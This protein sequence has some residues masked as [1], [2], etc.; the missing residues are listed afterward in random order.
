MSKHIVIIFLTLLSLEAVSQTTHNNE[1]VA[2]GSS[3]TKVKP[4][5]VIFTITVSKIDTS[6]KNS[7]KLLNL[8][9]N[10]LVKNLNEIGIDNKSIKISDYSISKSQN[11][12]NKEEYI[13]T[14][15]LKV[16][17]VIDTKLVNSLYNK[18]QEADLKDM[19]VS[20][21]TKLSDSLEKAIRLKL[22]Q[23]SIE[24]AKINANN[25]ANTLNI[26]L[27]GVKQVHK[28]SVEPLERDK[29][30]SDK[31]TP[32]RIVSDKAVAI[33]TP[34]DKFQVD[35]IELDEKITVVYEISD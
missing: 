33:N 14:N 11:E 23:Y 2:E 28:Y 22:V 17:F 24:D 6:E 12:H 35:D 7:I 9:I 32:P 20:Y 29:V 8:E 30:E 16:E 4:D 26:K 21:E 34:F 10:R 15:I 31:F 19:D 5:L 1:I 27:I 13:A 25:I 3:K 18:I